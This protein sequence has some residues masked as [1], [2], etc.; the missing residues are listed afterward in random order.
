M[1]NLKQRDCRFELIR[2]IACVFV[3]GVHTLWI[4]TPD[5]GIKGVY[6]KIVDTLFI[7]CNPI[8]FMLSGKFALWQGEFT[9]D[10]QYFRFYL[11]KFAYLILPMLVYMLFISAYNL[12]METGSFSGLL[13]HFTID[14]IAG[15]Q[16]SHLWFM[17]VLVGNVLM[18]PFTS[19]IFSSISRCGAIIFISILLLTNCLIAYSPYF[20]S[21][22]FAAWV[23]PF[24]GWS[25]YFYM[26]ACVDKIF[27]D[28]K[29]VNIL[30]IVGVISFLIIILKKYE[31]SYLNHIHDYMPSFT[32][33]SL[34]VYVL[35]TR[36]QFEFNEKSSLVIRFLGAQSFGIYLIHFPIVFALRDV[37]VI[38]TWC[39]EILFQYVYM[40]I[41]F[42]IS[43]ILS[44]LIGTF[45]LKPIQNDIEKLIAK[46]K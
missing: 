11:K 36:M 31:F 4:L 34:M 12:K 28:K 27:T 44:W 30:K 10:S 13:Y 8:F 25:L 20:F 2:V 37:F 41:V 40:I 46:I 16:A 18:S 22:S 1:R 17:Y 42:I 24:V 45:L 5:T 15:H 21:T 3:L 19:R 6:I 43:L 38:P 29:S 9:D 32:L 26:G 14:F 33:F 39:P 7:L 35:L 23:N